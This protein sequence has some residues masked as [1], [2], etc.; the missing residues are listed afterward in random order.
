M[1]CFVYFFF[2]QSVISLRASRGLLWK[3]LRNHQ[4]LVKV[5]VFHFDFFT[6]KYQMLQIEER[7]R[8]ILS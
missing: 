8:E 1:W 3:L 4:F 2:V 7:L 5:V 6:A